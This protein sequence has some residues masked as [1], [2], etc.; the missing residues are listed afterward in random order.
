MTAIPKPLVIESLS[1]EDLKSFQDDQLETAKKWLAEDDNLPSLL[2]LV[3]TK[4]AIPEKMKNGLKVMSNPLEISNLE[5]VP[6]DKPVFVTF[7]LVSTWKNLFHMMMHVP[8]KHQA[9]LPMLVK[10]AE[11][12]DI[13]D[14]FMRVMRP[15]MQVSNLHEKDIQALFM[16]QMILE[17]GAYAFV[18]M[19]EAYTL[20]SPMK[21][22]ETKEEAQDRYKDLKSNPKSIECIMVMLETHKYQRMIT[23]PF[24]R[25]KRD[26]G[27]VTGFGEPKIYEVKE[28]NDN[29]LTGRFVNMLRPL[30]E[31]EK[32]KWN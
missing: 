24:T 27:K 7:D 16:R 25:E 5:E 20:D 22:G 19:D 23:L 10:S 13:D 11:D 32:T 8:G 1:L 28:G 31:D 17:L 4:D 2:F 29:S 3:T 21:E 14:P 30:P 26:T 12:M 6:F 15:F 18:K 9:I